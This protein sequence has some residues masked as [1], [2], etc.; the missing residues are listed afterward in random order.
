MEPDVTSTAN[1]VSVCKI[2]Q[3]WSFLKTHNCFDRTI[4][5]DVFSEPLQLSKMTSHSYQNP[6]R[7]KRGCSFSIHWRKFYS[8][9][10]QP[11]IFKNWTRPQSQTTKW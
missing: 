5:M 9:E 4:V 2:S 7:F 6:A 1:S 10:Y 11:N 8:A 3:L